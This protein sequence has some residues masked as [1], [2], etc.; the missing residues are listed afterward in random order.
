MDGSEGTILLDKQGTVI[1]LHNH[2]LLVWCHQSLTTCLYTAHQPSSSVVYSGL[3]D[4]HSRQL[5]AN[6]ASG[7]TYSWDIATMPIPQESGILP[8][9]LL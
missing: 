1:A 5:G 9:K 6:V 8:V 4:R 7:H 2:C 3:I